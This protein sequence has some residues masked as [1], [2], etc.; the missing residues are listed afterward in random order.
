MTYPGYSVDTD[1]DGIA[2]VA[3][4]DTDGDGIRESMADDVNGDG[5]F[6][7]DTLR[8]AD[9]LGTGAHGD[10]EGSGQDQDGTIEGDEA[11]ASYDEVSYTSEPSYADQL[12][13]VDL[14]IEPGGAE[15]VDAD[16]DGYTETYAADTDKDGLI[17]TILVD[18]DEN[19]TFDTIVGD[20]DRDGD[21]DTVGFDHNEDGHFDEWVTF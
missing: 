21:L 14:T 9:N 5:I 16:G 2:D 20:N 13:E 4:V 12:R 3:Y 15:W 7:W 10:G 18:T 6:E 11:Q 1:G 19:H 8:P 17:D